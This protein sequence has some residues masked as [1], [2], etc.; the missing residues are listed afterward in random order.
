MFF[1]KQLESGADL[2]FQQQ[3]DGWTYSFVL[4]LC[5]LS[6]IYCA[7]KMYA[8]LP[9]LRAR[10]CF[11]SEVRRQRGSCGAGAHAHM[12]CVV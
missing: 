8:I 6:I 9:P 5:F 2:H 11:C 3:K 7:D 10:G 12:R 4:L 1:N